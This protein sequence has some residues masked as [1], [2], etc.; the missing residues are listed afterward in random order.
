ML[1]A[2]SKEGL[3]GCSEAAHEHLKG[4][5]GVGGDV[6]GQSVDV[7]GVRVLAEEKE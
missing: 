1:H 6:L 7:V 3:R 2:G 5:V 4:F